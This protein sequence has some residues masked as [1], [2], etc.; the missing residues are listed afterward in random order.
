MSQGKITE[1]SREKGQLTILTQDGADSNR[2]TLEDAAGQLDSYLAK[3]Q[4][5]KAFDF[6][7]ASGDIAA[8]EAQ[9]QTL[10]SR[11]LD[12]KNFSMAERAFDAMLDPRAKDIR[13]ITTRIQQ[14]QK[15]HGRSADD[16]LGHYTVRCV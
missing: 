14:L 6:L 9:W 2:Y 3:N 16:I 8:N 7:V 5:D 1:V 10:V 13:D 15:E 12:G 4:L 11:A